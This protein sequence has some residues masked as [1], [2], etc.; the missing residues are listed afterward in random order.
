MWENKWQKSVAKIDAKKSGVMG[1][2][3]LERD[4]ALWITGAARQN[5]WFGVLLSNYRNSTLVK[6]RC[7]KKK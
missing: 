5:D 6:I 7:Y 2:M 4:C 1:L 3:G